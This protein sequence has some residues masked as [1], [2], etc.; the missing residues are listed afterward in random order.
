[1]V[2]V[3]P[4]LARIAGTAASRI[5]STDYRGDARTAGEYLRESV[6]KPSAY[7]VPG[8]RY[9]GPGGI[10]LMPSHYAAALQRND[11]DDLVAY[12]STLK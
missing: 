7:V 11:I 6:L 10:S 2:L 4:S 8:E 9:T 3:G 1:V 12:L 5:G